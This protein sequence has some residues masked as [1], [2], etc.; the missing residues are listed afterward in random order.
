M[1]CRRRTTEEEALAAPSPTYVELYEVGELQ[2]RARR[3][4][5]RLATCDLCPRRCGADRNRSVGACGVGRTARVASVVRHHG[6]EPVISGTRGSGTVFFAGCNLHCVYCQNHQISQG[7]GETYEALE[8]VEVAE[9]MLRLQDEGV[10]NINF[11]SPSHVVPQILEALCLAVGRGL[12]LPIVWNSNAYEDLSVLRELDGVVDVYLPDL[13]YA[14]DTMGKRLSGVV[15]YPSVAR[16]A[17][18]EMYA[19]VGPLELDEDGLARRG[20]IVRHLVLPHNASGTSSNLR[21]IA[22]L[23]EGVAL[24][25]MSQ[26]APAFR[27]H[28]HPLVGRRLKP[29]EYER[30]VELVASLGVRHGWVQDLAE[31][32][33]HYRPD[34]QDDAPFEQDEQNMLRERG[35]E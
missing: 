33:E 14:G 25:L 28:G 30:A 3:L 26:Y 4:R 10:H 22:E 11:V 1:A 32:P 35:D 7:G 19:Q 16:A 20:L 6:E 9:A 23:G 18:R 29:A 21:F 34:F 17:L 13:K 31:S 2:A 5:D 24:S 8:A 27:A 12:R 15:G